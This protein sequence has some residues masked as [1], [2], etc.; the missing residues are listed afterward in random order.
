MIFFSF[1]LISFVI[2]VSGIIGFPLICQPALRESIMLLV[3]GGRGTDLSW[4]STRWYMWY[5]SLE[6]YG[7]GLYFTLYFQYL[8]CY[9]NFSTAVCTTYLSAA[10]QTFHLIQANLLQRSPC[11]YLHVCQ[12]AHLPYCPCA[13]CLTV[14]LFLMI[15]FFKLSSH[16]SL[17]WLCHCLKKMYKFSQTFQC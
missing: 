2:V 1:V 5:I 3:C 13:A 7:M 11:C 10:F 8:P 14:Y 16:W 4:L 17:Y 9:N 12:P 15:L 6:G